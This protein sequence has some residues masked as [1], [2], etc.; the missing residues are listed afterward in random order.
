MLQPRG[1]RLD[2]QSTAGLP[3]VA[4]QS[5]LEQHAT[6]GTEAVAD[7]ARDV[8]QSGLVQSEGGDEVD[9]G[10]GTV[11]E[12]HKVPLP[13]ATDVM[14][15]SAAREVPVTD[16]PEVV[17]AGAVSVADGQGAEAVADPARDVPQS[18]FVQS[19]VPVSGVTEVMP[20]GVPIE[21]AVSDG[22]HVVP[23]GAP[24][25]VSV[26]D[27]QGPEA[28]ADP[29]RDA[30]QSGLVQIE[31]GDAVGAATSTS[32]LEKEDNHGTGM[33]ASA[34]REVP[35]TV[36]T[37]VMPA[38]TPPEV[39]VAKVTELAPAGAASDLEN[40]AGGMCSPSTGV[41]VT[42]LACPVPSCYRSPRMYGLGCKS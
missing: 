29:A 42:S 18:G 9:G 19:E 21:V 8:P 2:P 3:L 37:E 13:D 38:G 1:P 33:P 28:V 16:V 14:P 30:P 20:A 31:G 26:A 12:P 24:P 35:V 39:S 4:E 5:R 10:A 25:E 34:P 23:A 17:P 22:A 6:Q 11:S 27:G 41:A 40:T 32:G 7:P 36:A 15:A